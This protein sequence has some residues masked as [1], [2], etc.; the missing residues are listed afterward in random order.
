MQSG[1]A[2]DAHADIQQFRQQAA[3][4]W[5]RVHIQLL[6]EPL[7]VSTRNSATPTATHTQ[8]PIVFG[9]LGATDAWWG[10]K[11][12]SGGGGGVGKGEAEGGLDA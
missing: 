4:T 5:I 6:S 1:S 12:G 8:H 10:S 7:C 2:Q 9:Q 11:G 3:Y